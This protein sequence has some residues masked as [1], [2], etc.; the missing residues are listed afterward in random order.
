MSQV[1]AR[2]KFE[3]RAKFESGSIFLFFNSFLLFISSGCYFR[4]HNDGLVANR[5]K[6]N[7][8]LFAIFFDIDRLSRYHYDSLSL[9]KDIPHP[10]VF[11]D[12]LR[13]LRPVF[14]YTWSRDPF[15][16][17]R[18][19][20]VKEFLIPATQAPSYF[21]RTP[22]MK[23][24]TS[25]SYFLCRHNVDSHVIFLSNT[26]AKFSLYLRTFYKQLFQR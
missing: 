13:R 5:K 17:L 25:G 19:L 24:N 23:C 21:H 4:L 22:K 3:S 6:Y 12:F 18:K 7:Y 2:V 20:T 26:V 10:S 15:P 14:A 11:M 8:I 9:H 16:Q 1:Q